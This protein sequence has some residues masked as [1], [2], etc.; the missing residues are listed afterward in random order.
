MGKITSLFAHKVLR[1]VDTSEDKQALLRSIGIDPSQP[2]DPRLM[3]D[4]A[5][6]YAFYERAARLDSQGHTLPLR[7][8]ESMTPDDYGAFGLAWKSALTPRDSCERLVRYA[9]VLTSVAAYEIQKTDQG[10]KMILNRAGPRQLGLRLSNETTIAAILSMLRQVSTQAVQ[11]IEVYLKHSAPDITDDHE[12]YFGCPVIFNAETDALLFTH[13]DMAQPNRKGDEGIVR[14]IDSHLDS[15][16][17]KLPDDTSLDR[18]VKNAVTVSLSAGV[19]KISDVAGQLGM[20]GRTLQRRLSE[21]GLSYQA[22]VDGARRELATSLLAETD[23]P[24][25]EV[26]FLAGFSEQS[27]FNR[28]FRRWAGETPRSYRLKA[29]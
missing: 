23:Y 11:P 15:E 22:V 14:F 10:L 7:V 17:A 18:Q 5:D 21:K 16:V 20:S 6:Y 2:V 29:N 19:P 24:L 28:A 9:L 1:Q 12:A 25:A 4:D 3:V 27:A 13:G 8:G 26:A